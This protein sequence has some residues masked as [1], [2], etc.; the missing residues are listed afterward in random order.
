MVYTFARV[1]A[2]AR[3]N[4]GHYF[5][6]GHRWMLHLQEK[7]GKRRDIPVHHKAG[8]YLDRYRFSSPAVGTPRL[9]MSKRDGEVHSE[10]TRTPSGAALCYMER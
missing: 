6:A 10:R 3:L 9:A 5:Q 4:V 2:V 8:E 7:G 1:S